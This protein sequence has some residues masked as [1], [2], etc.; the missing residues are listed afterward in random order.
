MLSRNLFLLSIF[1]F[2]TACDGADFYLPQI[3][4]VVIS[5][6]TPAIISPTPI[7]VSAVTSTETSLA[8]ST[9]T[10]VATLLSTESPTAYPSITASLEPTVES[11]A[12]P[13][14]TVDIV[15]CNTSLDI[16]HQMGE[17]TNGFVLVRNMG[18]SDLTDVCATLSASDEAR[19]H[20][21]KTRCAI[22]LPAGYQVTL[23]LTVDTGF[24]EDTSIRVEVIS[25]E[26]SSAVASRNSCREIGLP[27]WVSKD[28]GF[29]SPIP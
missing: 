3:T 5:S 20:P 15:G 22:S 17:V 12:Q 9:P 23:K 25:R 8:S 16:S 14:L 29:P 27:D 19:Q 6:K 21:E 2:L 11:T 4:P 18:P 7:F 24:R 26:G 28:I 13:A 1:I 10:G